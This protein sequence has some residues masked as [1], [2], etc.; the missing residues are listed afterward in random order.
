MECNPVLYSWVAVY[1]NGS[2]LSEFDGNGRHLFKEIDQDKLDQLSWASS[3]PTKTTYTVHIAPWQRVILFRRHHFNERTGE[4]Y[5]LYALGW[6]ATIDGRNYK[7][8][9]F[10]DPQTNTARITENLG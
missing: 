10:I 8:I 9:L 7:S 4:D 3:D 1:N 2:S 6:Q 5:V